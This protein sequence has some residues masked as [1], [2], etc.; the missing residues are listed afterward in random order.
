MKLLF[1]RAL[2]ADLWKTECGKLSIGVFHILFSRF[3]TICSTW[4]MLISCC[5]KEEFCSNAKLQTDRNL[6]TIK[7]WKTRIDCGR[8]TVFHVEQSRSWKNVEHI[9][10]IFVENQYS[11]GKQSLFHVEHFVVVEKRGTYPQFAVDNLGFF[12]E[13]YQFK[14]GAEP[15]FCSAFF[16]VRF[17]AL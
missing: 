6:L 10:N 15:I 8:R 7:L 5:G 2:L 13:N 16:S 17:S 1:H 9:H 14:N 12:V 3:S 11:C 4:N